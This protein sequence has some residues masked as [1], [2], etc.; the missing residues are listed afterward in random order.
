[1]E[2]LHH[3]SIF[4]VSNPYDWSRPVRSKKSFAG[5]EEHLLRVQKIFSAVKDNLAVNISL[6]GKRAS[7]KTSMLNAIRDICHDKGGVAVNIDLN[8]N[9]VDSILDFWAEVIDGIITNG[10]PKGLWA[11]SEEFN[12]DQ[13]N[14]FNTWRRNVDYNEVSDNLEN[15]GIRFGDIYANAVANN[16]KVTPRP[17][18]IE[19]DLEFLVENLHGQGVPFV[20]I[21]VDE[22]DLF[23]KNMGLLQ[24]LRY[25]MQNLQNI[26]FVFA[27]TE[28]MF[29]ALD[30]VFSPIPRQFEKF[31][32]DN[33]SNLAETRDC[34]YK[35]LE[36]LGVRRHEIEQYISYSM[37]NELHERT[38]GNPYH[39]KLLLHYIFNN[40][41]ENK[42][43]A[44]NSFAIDTNIL[45]KV[46]RNISQATKVEN[47]DIIRKLDNCNDD[48]LKAIGLL[49]QYNGLTLKEAAEIKNE[50]RRSTEGSFR[51]AI[52]HIVEQLKKIDHHEIFS[53]GDCVRY[54]K[55]NIAYENADKCKLLFLGDHLDILFLDYFL[56]EKLEIS[57]P[58]KRQWRS[59]EEAL[60]DKFVH[61][62][63]SEVREFVQAQLGKPAPPIFIHAEHENMST[64]KYEKLRDRSLYTILS[65]IHKGL[66]DSQNLD[67]AYNSAKDF[68]LVSVIPFIVGYNACVITTISG[69]FRSS[70]YHI[71]VFQPLDI[72]EEEYKHVDELKDS[73]K[74]L[75]PKVL[76]FSNQETGTQ[77]L[78]P[79][80]YGIQQ[81]KVEWI[82]INRTFMSLL[83]TLDINEKSQLVQDYVRRGEYNLALKFLAFTVALTVDPTRSNNL[84]FIYMLL[85]DFSKAR[86]Y[87]D[88]V[89]KN[90][91]GIPIARYNQAY[92]LY[93]E[94]NLRKAEQILR[95]LVKDQKTIAK[96]DRTMDC[97]KV[98]FC[99]PDYL[100]DREP[101]WD[102][103]FNPDIVA[104]AYIGLAS[105]TSMNNS[106]MSAKKF[107]EKAREIGGDQLFLSRASAW[108]A[109]REGDICT[110]SELLNS[111]SVDE[112]IEEQMRRK[113]VESDR[114]YFSVEKEN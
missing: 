83:A 98:I 64:A 104:A 1:M 13:S 25:I 109:H 16:T 101:D 12:G 56:Q 77:P 84:G 53:V 52:D 50:F 36:S 72:P 9:L 63:G 58:N 76:L 90:D 79:E 7:G 37:L 48:E 29:E 70:K 26:V 47:R 74:E 96:E 8:E 41:V 108:I 94:G 19:N 32:I 91:P 2:N 82:T 71:K 6:T 59:Y 57:L 55:M 54:E 4:K 22:A 10:I 111:L 21:L 112:N 89:L 97:L 99:D 93:A 113:S 106:P 103:V 81:E 11:D 43:K 114:E 88:K 45:S 40:F 66:E 75:E 100:V 49:F 80:A 78:D 67:V 46:F 14:Y 30:D 31:N 51:D 105:I 60:F 34:V 39:L 38:G 20:V 17:K 61:K 33:F 3:K 15:Q 35:P 42:G 24:Q 65:E 110:A 95:Q 28:V 85:D 44:D 27:G 102:L 5:R 68:G 87:I 23:V 62:V 107:M 86:E 18:V 69:A 92:I 73:Y